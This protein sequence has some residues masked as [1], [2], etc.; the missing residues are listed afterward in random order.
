MTF[1]ALPKPGPPPVAAAVVSAAD[2]PRK[3][4]RR[5][6]PKTAEP[7]TRRKSRRVG[8][9]QVSV[10]ANPGMTSMGRTLKARRGSAGGTV[11]QA[12]DLQKGYAGRAP[13]ATGKSRDGRPWALDSAGAVSP[14]TG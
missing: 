6:R 10:P 9:S 12:L 13:V 4:S 14:R 2:E 3:K 11:G 7:P 5:D 1:F 8:P